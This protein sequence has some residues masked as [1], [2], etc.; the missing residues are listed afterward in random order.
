MEQDYLLLHPTHNQIF[1]VK[2]DHIDNKEY[3]Y[4]FNT[5]I[6][7]IIKTNNLSGNYKIVNLYNGSDKEFTIKKSNKS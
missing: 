5:N 1:T 6:K 4:I 7:N 3:N 2:T